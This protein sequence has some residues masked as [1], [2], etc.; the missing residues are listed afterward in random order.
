MRA[1]VMSV[2]WAVI[3][4]V[5]QA[6]TENR[7]SVT[8]EVAS[9]KRSAD[10]N[11][12][13]GETGVPPILPPRSQGVLTYRRVSMIGLLARAYAVRPNEIDGPSWLGEALYDIA[14]KI[15]QEE[16]RPEQIQMMLQN[17]LADRVRMR[18]HW[19]TQRSRGYKLAV[20]KK[21]LRISRT[22]F[23][24]G[25]SPKPREGF[26]TRDGHVQLRFRDLTMDDIAKSLTSLLGLPVEN[27]T[28]LEGEFTI[29]LDCDPDSLPGLKMMSP[30]DQS[31][32]AQSV[33][34]AIR[35]LGLD[36]VPGAV[37]AK[38]LVVDAADAIP[39]DN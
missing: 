22:I 6:Q 9:L 5:A 26:A 38:R 17:L 32:P 27:A 30:P 29:S 25:A 16:E 23:E 34:T 20:G 39:I 7:Q 13:R 12:Q 15:P 18:T 3:A 21:T 11:R 37:T 28:G 4:S 2:T 19:D 33:M 10:Q 35:N 1:V 14:A 36:L 24:P 31:G 8:F